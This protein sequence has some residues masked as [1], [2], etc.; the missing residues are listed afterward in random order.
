MTPFEVTALSVTLKAA[1]IVPPANSRCV[2]T[3][4]INNKSHSD[5]E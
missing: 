5:I 1:G 3:R 4:V 2:E